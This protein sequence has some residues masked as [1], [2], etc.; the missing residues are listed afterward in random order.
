MGTTSKCWFSQWLPDYHVV[1]NVVEGFIFIYGGS[2]AASSTEG[3]GIFHQD[4][5][6]EE[7]SRYFLGSSAQNTV[8]GLSSHQPTR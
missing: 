5:Y 6:A 1:N 3:L 8:L 4:D 7:K 2:F